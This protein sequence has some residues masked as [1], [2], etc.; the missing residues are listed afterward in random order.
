MQVR[1]DCFGI[2]WHTIQLEY[3]HVPTNAGYIYC[4]KHEINK[5]MRTTDT[6]PDFAPDR[7]TSLFIRPIQNNKP[8]IIICALQ[9]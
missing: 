2:G 8:K 1:E 4:K 5:K 7:Y 6:T 9:I 3:T